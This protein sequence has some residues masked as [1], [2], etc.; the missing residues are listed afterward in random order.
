MIDMTDMQVNTTLGAGICFLSGI[1]G[2]ILW[3]S[4][5]KQNNQGKQEIEKIPI[6][7]IAEWWIKNGAGH[8]MATCEFHIEKLAPLWREEKAAQD[9]SE[10]HEFQNARIQEFY[11]LHIQR[12]RHASQPSQHHAICSE[13]LSLLDKEGNCSSVV[14]VSRDV[15]ASWNSTTYTLLGQTNLMDHSLNV[16]EEAIR[17]LEESDAGYIVPDALIVALAHDIG[18]L[19]SIKGY[20]YSLGEHPLTAGRVLSEIDAFGQLAKK[21]ELLRAIKLHHKHPD[22]LLGKTLKR[23][24]QLAR[25][26]E[27]DQAQERLPPLEAPV[28]SMERPM[29]FLAEEVVEKKGEAPKLLNIS[30]W[31]DAMVMLEQMKPQINQLAGRRFAAFSMANGYVYFQ[32]KIIEEIARKQAEQAGVL[33]VVS[34]E[35]EEMRQV[36]LSIVHQLRQED[37]IADGLLQRNY[38]GAYF[39]ITMKSG[40]TMKGYYTPFHA[41]PF[42]SIAT[43]EKS[44]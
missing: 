27:L 26:K 24:D 1:I 15:E 37:V 20:L 19:P 7:R 21:D 38:F 44:K 2:L 10:D 28:K 25:Q 43:M 16:A 17:L 14:N 22:N 32:P 39:T 9:V 13:L 11:K 23:A 18:K 6:E 5:K 36:L 42:G 33:D 40:V 8:G 3:R 34:M 41:E 30:A 35:T 12:L 4:G 29:D 31:F